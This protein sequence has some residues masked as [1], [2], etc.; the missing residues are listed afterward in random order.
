[1]RVR[2]FVPLLT[3]SVLSLLVFIHTIQYGYAFVKIIF[4]VKNQ[5]ILINAPINISGISE[6][7]KYSNCKIM[8]VI[9]KE[10]PYREVIPVDNFGGDFSKWSFMLTSDYATLD[11]G[12][13]KITSK[14]ECDIFDESLIRDNSTGKYIK[15]FSINVTGIS[16]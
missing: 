14:T 2:I 15:H 7:T 9:N 16:N 10:F 11:L 12:E 3:I 4:P 1:M 5:H 8:L 13:N 6:D